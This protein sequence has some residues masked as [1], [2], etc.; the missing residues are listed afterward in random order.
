M[1]VSQGKY[2]K[3]SVSGNFFLNKIFKDSIECKLVVS[4]MYSNLW[5]LSIYIRS[6][7]VKCNPIVFEAREEG[8][9]IKKDASQEK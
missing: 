9:K 6:G 3:T 4:Q 1:C 8:E 7:V 2:Y 5:N